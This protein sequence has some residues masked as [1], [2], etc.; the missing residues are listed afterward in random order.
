MDLTR[1][2]TA[3]AD[4]LLVVID[5]S[6]PLNGDDMEI[7]NQCE[8]RNA[9]VVINKIDL[10]PSGG[11]RDKT[12]VLNRFKR[13]EI[14]ALTGQGIDRLRTTI[15]ETI[16]SDDTLSAT[17]SH[18]VPN[19]RHRRALEAAG[20]CFQNASIEARNNAPMEIVAFETQNRPGTLGGNYRADR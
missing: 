8:N 1:Q 9:L 12:D 13:V 11:Y 10:P 14:S 15:K 5:R 3:E 2:K 6:R 19:L 4:L 20:K 7:L 16:L 17:T 18:A